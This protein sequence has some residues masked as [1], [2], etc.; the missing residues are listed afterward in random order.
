[1]NEAVV[2]YNGIFYTK[3]KGIPDHIIIEN[4]L[5]AYANVFCF[6]RKKLSGYIL[7][8]WDTIDFKELE[9]K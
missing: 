5:D 6:S 8:D 7:R 1:M 3:I 4:I 9:I 2:L